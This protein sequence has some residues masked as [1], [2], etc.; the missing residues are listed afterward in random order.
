M[1]FMVESL[2]R[3][4]S[5]RLG[6]I[7]Y[8]TPIR[9]SALILGKVLANGVIA[10]VTVLAVFATCAV[11]LII[12]GTV[13]LDVGPY[14]LVYGLLLGPTVLIWSAFVA[15]VFAVTG[16]RFTTYAIA[17]GA[18]IAGAIQLGLGK[19]TWVWNWSLEGALRWSDI[20]PF[21]PDRTPLVLN[22]L[23]VLT[24]A[25]FFV[26]VAVR[27]FPRRSFDDMRI[28]Q[29]LHPARLLKTCLLLLPFAVAPIAL[30]IVLQRGINAGPQGAGVETWSKNYWRRNHATWL[31]VPLPDVARSDVDL[32][33]EPGRR[34]FHTRGTFE[35][36]NG[37][38]QSLATIPLTGGPHWKQ[39][40]W[41]LNGEAYEPEDRQGLHL[42]TLPEP[43]APGER[44]TVGFDF[45]GEFPAGFTRNGDASM[46]FIVPTGIVLTSTTPSFV[47]V[48]GYMEGIGVDKK[49]RYDSR[50]YPADFHE[51]VTGA[52]FGPDRPQLTR[53]RITAP[54]EYTM[55]SV[56]IMTDSSVKNGKR[57]VTWESDYPVDTFNV[58]GGRWVVRRGEGTAIFHHPEHDYNI[59][60]M[61]EALDGARRHY[62]QWFHPYPW[63]E[64]KL[65]EFPALAPY[66]QGFATNITFSEGAGFLAES[67]AQSNV[68]FLVTAH[69]AAHQWWGGLLV[70]GDGPGGNLLSEG[71]SH[72]STILLFEAARGLQQRIEFCRMIEERYC[73]KRVVDAERPLVEIDGSRDGDGTVTYDKAGWVFWMLLEQ[74][75]RENA[76]RGLSSFFARYVDNRDHP[77]LQDFIAHMRSFALDPVAYQEFVDQWFFDVVLPE[78]DLREVVRGPE[79]GGEGGTEVRLV[80]RNAGT[81]RMPV[82][83]SAE[84]GVRFP[85]AGNVA[86]EPFRDSRTTVV[87][88]AGEEREVR[89]R[90]DFEP[91]RIVV[92]P[93]AVTIQ[94]DRKGAIHRF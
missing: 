92:D 2:R 56:G 10:A 4:Q 20:A 64:L 11:L 41:T 9:T 29:R 37:T 77:V 84:R 44:C 87:L 59:D 46:E 62:S 72:F 57:T 75:G 65:S 83:I 50:E 86:A 22:R 51:G 3:E 31:D 18:L 19:M 28:L 54:E 82:V 34:W 27:L 40:R 42:F 91:E 48:V 85:S 38:E 12:Q 63:A 36:A 15:M 8:A 23:L 55:N 45:E 53:V 32:E 5:T 67:D 61:I 25:V 24:A 60:E 21:E 17:I 69:E 78:Y 58:I 49:N 35:L 16:N 80:V 13:P 90:C 14:A 71:T 70:P 6:S 76:M 39:T 52:L 74:M 93:D 88:G 79:D 89:I 33:L 30:G 81:G 1:F 26:V 94:N 73:V 7:L 66:A 68:P 43:L 47:P